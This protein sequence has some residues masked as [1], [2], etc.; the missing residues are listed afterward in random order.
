MIIKNKLSWFFTPPMRF[1][2]GF[3]CIAGIIPLFYSEY[4]APILLVFGLA[5]ISLHSGIHLNTTEKKYKLYYKLFWIFC[6]GKYHSFESITEINLKTKKLAYS[7]FSRSNR[8]IENRF[9]NYLVSATLSPTG[10][11]VPLFISNNK[12]L[13]ETK[14]KKY[15]FIKLQ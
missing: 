15:E 10:I 6:I 8:H 5:I 4:T 7:T 3:L 1:A 14:A 2:G 12:A 11:E 9:T 13:A